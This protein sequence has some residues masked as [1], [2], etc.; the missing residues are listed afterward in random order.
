MYSELRAHADK[1]VTNT[2][3]S[4]ENVNILLIKTRFNS[5][6]CHSEIEIANHRQKFYGG[7]LKTTPD[8]LI[9]KLRQT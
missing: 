7:L 5:Y 6:R 3:V 2:I 1:T 4:N 8:E 9:K